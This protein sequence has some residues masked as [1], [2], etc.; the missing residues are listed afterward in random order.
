M[1]QCEET[2]QQNLP[3][4]RQIL[5]GS[6]FADFNGRG[7]GIEGEGDSNYSL[8]VTW[9]FTQTCTLAQN[10]SFHF[11]FCTHWHFCT[12]ITR[13]HYKHGAPMKR[14][15]VTGQQFILLISSSTTIV[16]TLVSLH[17][18]V[19]SNQHRFQA[20]LLLTLKSTWVEISSNIML[21]WSLWSLWS[22]EFIYANYRVSSILMEADFAK[23]NLPANTIDK[24]LTNIID[25]FQQI[26]QPSVVS[27]IFRPFFRQI[28]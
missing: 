4:S 23:H 26:I 11:Y 18:G 25:R 21:G 12:T 7:G 24:Y 16:T 6:K 20:S 27:K 5:S 8:A 19:V 9:P 17:S 3:Q 1:Q 2:V 14:S 22:F 15:C 13:V 10:Y 28:V